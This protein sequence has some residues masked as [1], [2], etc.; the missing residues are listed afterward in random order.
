MRITLACLALALVAWP[1]FGLAQETD[2]S[3]APLDVRTYGTSDKTFL[4][5]SH[6][7]F[8]GPSASS[9]YES[10]SSGGTAVKRVGGSGVLVAP[11]NLPDGAR[12]TEIQAVICDTSA[13]G[14]GWSC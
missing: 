11:V 7:H 10:G 2:S 4:S 6:Q 9:S 13:T 12:V 1:A 3:P 14:Q 5:L 8:A